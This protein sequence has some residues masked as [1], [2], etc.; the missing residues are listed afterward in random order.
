MATLS[1]RAALVEASFF[2]PQGHSL[3]TED[4]PFDKRGANGGGFWYLIIPIPNS[5]VEG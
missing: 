3:P 4:R 5:V 2:D 1:V